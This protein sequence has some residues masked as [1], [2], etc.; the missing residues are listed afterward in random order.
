M[1]GT[2]QG[3]S[4][5]F[6]LILIINRDAVKKVALERGCLFAEL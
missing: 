1:I 4:V 2:R 5:R 6:A 3:G